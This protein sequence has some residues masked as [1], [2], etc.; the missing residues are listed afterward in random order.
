MFAPE[1]YF[2]YFMHGML[3]V[4]LVAAIFYSQGATKPETVIGFNRAMLWPFAILLT[5]YIGLRPIS[6]VFVDMPTYATAYEMAYYRGGTLFNDWGFNLLNELCVQIMSVESF[7]LVCAG[8]Y[9]FPLMIGVSRVHREWAFSALL[10][11]V[12]ALQFFSYGVNGIRNGL[13][14]SLLIAAFAFHD[15]RIAM[16]ALMVA[17]ESMHK[18]AL[19]PI[20]AFL[21]AGFYPSPAVFGAVWATCLLAVLAV[22]ER[23]AAITARV[24]SFTGEDERLSNYALGSGLGGDKGGFRIDFVLYS[25]VPLLLAWAFATAQT[26]ADKFFRRLVC[27]Y[28]ITN[29]FWLLMMY[30][31]QSNRFAYL[32][33]FMMPW[34]IIYPFIP[35]AMPG[36]APRAPDARIGLLPAAILAAFGFTYVMNMFIYA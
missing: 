19:L 23:L 1:Q 17:A 10:V 20:A 36:V 24:L 9:V 27:T 5:L 15:R 22:G 12:G 3:A 28:L 30:A 8:L 14:C 33:W 13:S 25:I 7:F 31:A 4:S 26:R 16:V 2:P 35:S 11:F 32:S 29:S 6:G 18:S 21:V 34:I